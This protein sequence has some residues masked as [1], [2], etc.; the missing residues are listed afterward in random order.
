MYIYVYKHFLLFVLDVLFM[1]CTNTYDSQLLTTQHLNQSET[2]NHFVSYDNQFQNQCWN[3]LVVNNGPAM[4]IF[5]HT[6]V[7]WLMW[8]PYMED[9][10]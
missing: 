3:V 2:T 9:D 5:V 1:V 8:K 4:A 10:H 7:Y 6:I